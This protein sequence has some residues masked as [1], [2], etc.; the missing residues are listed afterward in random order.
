MARMRQ[1]AI[2]RG[3]LPVR[4]REAS[5]AKVVPR[6]FCTTTIC[7]CWHRSWA[8]WGGVARWVCS[9]PFVGAVGGSR[10]AS[11]LTARPVT[12]TVS[13]SPG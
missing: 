1:V 11:R 5:A 13:T 9:A 4:T 6:T 2:A 12:S 10:A 8:S 7:Q 3:A